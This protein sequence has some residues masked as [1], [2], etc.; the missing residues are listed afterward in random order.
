LIGVWDLLGLEEAGPDD[1]F[2]FDD[3]VL[4]NEKE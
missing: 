2:G 4:V 3:I 1:V